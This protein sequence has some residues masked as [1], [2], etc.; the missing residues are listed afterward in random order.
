MWVC[1]YPTCLWSRLSSF[2][3]VEMNRNFLQVPSIHL[4][5]FVTNPHFPCLAFVRSLCAPR[6]VLRYTTVYST[7]LSVFCSFTRQ[8]SY[9]SFSPLYSIRSLRLH[10]FHFHPPW[11]YTH[12]SRTPFSMQ[13]SVT[14]SLDFSTTLPP[15]ETH[16]RFALWGRDAQMTVDFAVLWLGICWRRHCAKYSNGLKHS[17]ISHKR[18]IGNWVTRTCVSGSEVMIS[19]GCV[20]RITSPKRGT[21][22]AKLTLTVHYPMDQYYQKF[23]MFSLIV[24]L[25]LALFYF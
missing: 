19:V 21:E 8:P 13:H 17:L 4:F 20:F 25:F 12:L 18:L 10:P 24:S 16:C 9:F 11:V 14:A 22:S 15:F 3:I 23:C 5:M 6:S 2:H 7:Y 1:S